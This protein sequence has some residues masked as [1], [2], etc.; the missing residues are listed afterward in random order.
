MPETLNYYQLGQGSINLLF[1]HGLAS[2]SGF[3][4]PLISKIN[5]S[6]YTIHSFDLKGHGKSSFYDKNF[7]P[8]RLSCEVN[9]SV[10][11]HNLNDFILICHS[12]GGRVGLNMLLSA[13][14][15]LAPSQLLILDTYWPEYQLRPTLQ[16]VLARSTDIINRDPETDNVPVSATQALNLMRARTQKTTVPVKQK[17]S[18]NIETWGKIITSKELC[19]TLDNQVDEYVNLHKIKDFKNKIKL[20]YGGD[21]LFL[22]SGQEAN[23]KLGLELHIISKARHFFPR[24]QTAELIELINKLKK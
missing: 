5:K 14:S 21:S 20:I 16:S 7:S 10:K 11:K 15:S 13:T 24:F 3:W 9:E 22:T 17:R 23:K 2:D 8:S 1:L 6:K 18:K 19:Q 12:Y 4:L